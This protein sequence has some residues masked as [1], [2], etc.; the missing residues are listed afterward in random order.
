LNRLG[1]ARVTRRLLIA[2]VVAAAGVAMSGCATGLCS[3]AERGDVMEARRLLDQGAK[4]EQSCLLGATP[5]HYAT[6]YKRADVAT[7]LLARGANVNAATTLGDTPLH[8]AAGEGDLKMVAL[9]LKAGA[10]PTIV[11][12]GYT[13][14]MRAE[15]GDYTAIAKLLHEAEGKSVGDTQPEPGTVPLPPP[16]KPAALHASVLVME[17]KRVGAVPAQMPSVITDLLL[18]RLDDVEGLRTVSPQDLQLMLSVEKQ[19]DALGCDDVRCIAEV[20]GALGTDF[21]IYGEIGLAG[22][23]YDLTLTAIDAKHSLAVARV[24][25]LVAANEDALVQSVPGAVASLLNKMERPIEAR[26]ARP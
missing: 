11:A 20:G 19:R 14:A 5:L 9:L 26:P 3:A 18:A 17:L 13:P 4:T 12:R 6:H 24:S 2:L 1:N 25:S 21:V 7:L 10:D 16:V 8:W 15:Q 23:Q 22:S